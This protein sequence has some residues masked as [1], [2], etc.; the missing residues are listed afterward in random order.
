[1]GSMAYQIPTLLLKNTNIM[2]CPLSFWGVST[3]HVDTIA[4]PSPP[5]GC[6]WP[7]GSATSAGRWQCPEQDRAF[8]PVVRG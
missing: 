8:V 5:A 1:M 2:L 7:F 4:W 6:D 3:A